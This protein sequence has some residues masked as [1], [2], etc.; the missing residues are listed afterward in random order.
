M[1]TIYIDIFVDDRFYA[2]MEYKYNPIFP[3][4]QNDLEAAVFKKYTYLKNRK[5]VEIS[6]SKCHVGYVKNRKKRPF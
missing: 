4:A 1:K 6:M 5:N 3:I 2:Q